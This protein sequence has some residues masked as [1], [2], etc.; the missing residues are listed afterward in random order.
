MAIKFPEKTWFTFQD[1]IERWQCTENDIRRLVVDKSLIPSIR[2]A[3]IL[4][5][6]NWKPNS[7]GHFEPSGRLQHR[8][9]AG[10]SIEHTPLNHWLYLR[11]PVRTAAFDCEFRLATFE[12]DTPEPKTDNDVAGNGILWSWLPEVMTMVSVVREAAFLLEEVARFEAKHTR[13]EREG[14]PDKPLVTKERNTLLTIIAVLCKESNLDYKTHAK[15]AGLIQN[16]AA[17]MGISIGETTIE[18][19]LKKVSDALGSRMK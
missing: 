18:N 11:R 13:K 15:T 14:I 5:T 3:E 6:P 12:I 10:R 4:T 2:T 16:T 19:H 9:D 7:S 17:S 1:L 8:G